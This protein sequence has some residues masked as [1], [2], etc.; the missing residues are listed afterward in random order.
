M[1]KFLLFAFVIVVFSVFFLLSSCNKS[2][3][4]RI[5]NWA[6]YIPEEVIQQFE[7]EYNC[8]VIYDTFASNEEM[9][10]KIKS[11][12]T[13]YDIVFPSGDHVKMMIN[14]GLLEK[15][16][17]SK[18]PNFK[19]I[20]PIVLSKTTYDPNHEYS[21][22]YMMGTTGLIVNKKYLKD[23][24]KSWSIYERADLKGKMTLLDDM[25]EVFG[26]ALKYLGY[27][28]NTTNPDEIEQAKQVILKWK[29]NIV[30]FDA[31]TYAQGV[32]NGE[33]WVVH[34]YPENVFQLIPEE[35]LENF[36]FFVPKEG[37]TLWIDNMVILKDAKN[38]DL[39]YKFINF[40][41]RPEIAAQISDYLMIPSPITDAQKY[42]K[43]EP[44]YTLDELSNCEIIDYIGEHIDLYNKAWEEIIK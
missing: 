9:F 43:V 20:D 3:V 17:L 37:G 7:K 41:L 38:K 28:V 1:K 39:A 34:G 33:F 31:T 19:N 16:D 15:L 4:L 35:D 18:I 23:Y 40:I 13:G 14:E 21:V 22:P 2:N 8:K 26:A 6:D 10:A 36:E 12:G 25:R 5:Y 44:L 11:G 29:E 42:K 24:E 32:V 27:S 30:K